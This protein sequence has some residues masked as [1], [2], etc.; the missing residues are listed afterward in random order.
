M[1]NRFEENCIR[2][3]Q[4]SDEALGMYLRCVRREGLCITSNPVEIRKIALKKEEEAK[5]L[6]RDHNRAH[7]DYELHYKEDTREEREA[8]W[9]KVI[10]TNLSLPY[11]LQ[12]R[13]DN[14]GTFLE[15]M[16]NAVGGLLNRIS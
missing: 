4:P 11:V 10:E 1:L 9:N 15:K 16:M 13:H 3:H 2:Y 12:A 8:C 5:L 7:A 6:I 14:A